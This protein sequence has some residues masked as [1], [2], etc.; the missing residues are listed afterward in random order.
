MRE[1]KF[2]AWIISAQQMVD[3]TGLCYT[4]NGLQIECLRTG[5]VPLYDNKAQE[6]WWSGTEAIL[7]EFTGLHDKNGN[8]YCEG[9]V[10]KG[11]LWTAVEVVKYEGGG[12]NPFA[13][14]GWEAVPK[15][16]DLRIIGN[17]YENPELLE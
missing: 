5:T 9:D 3:V 2:R 11:E 10:V 7:R 17:I 15:P 12:F 14:P 16:E 1:P 4:E 13:I 8:E 6:W